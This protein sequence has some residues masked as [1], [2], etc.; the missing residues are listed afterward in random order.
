MNLIDDATSSTYTYLLP[1]KSTTIK[2]LKEWVLL[3]EREMGRKVG[4]LNINNGELKSI[5]FIEFCASRGIKPC[6]TAPSTSAQMVE[7]SVFI[8]LNSIRHGQCELQHYCPQTDGMNLFSLPPTYRCMF[9]PNHSIILCPMRFIAAANLTFP[10]YM[11][12]DAL[13]LSSS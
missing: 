11:K 12:L 10:I 13:P 7:L 9:Q 4:S 8:I 5:E 1:L 6:W 2:V 3:A